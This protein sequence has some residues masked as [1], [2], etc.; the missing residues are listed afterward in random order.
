MRDA[1]VKTVKKRSEA[2]FCE[3]P[4]KTKAAK[5]KT[6]RSAFYRHKGQCRWEGIQDEQYKIEDGGWADVVR[7]VLIGNHGES[8]KFH[9]RYFEISPG[10][11]SS[12]ERHR[13][14]HVVICIRGEGFVRTGQKKRKMKFLDTIYISPDAAHQLSNPFDEPFGFLCIVNADRDRPIVLNDSSGKEAM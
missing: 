2:S 10:G 7:R 6:N 3:M 5:V 8:S 14:E 4:G 9:V 12:L 1:G 13:H 11:F